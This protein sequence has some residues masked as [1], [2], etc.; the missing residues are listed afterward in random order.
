MARTQSWGIFNLDKQE[1]IKE[2]GTWHDLKS[3]LFT[4]SV[5]SSRLI[6]LLSLPEPK[7]LRK[8][9]GAK[10]IYIRTSLGQLNRIPLELLDMVFAAVDDIVDLA[11]LCLVNYHML[12]VGRKHFD[13]H[14]RKHRTWTGDRLICLGS[15]T[16]LKDLP[17]DLLTPEERVYYR[18]KDQ[19]NSMGGL[20]YDILEILYDHSR[21][22]RYRV[23]AD[24]LQGMQL[25]EKLI[26]WDLTD[27]IYPIDKSWVLC[28]LSKY[29]YVTARAISQYTSG[30]SVKGPYFCSKSIGFTQVLVSQICW[31]KS[32]DK[33]I[34][35]S[36]DTPL[37][38]GR[39]AG[40]RFEI[41]T[42]DRMKHLEGG[43]EWK[44]VSPMII[45][46]LEAIWRNHYGVLF[47][48][49]V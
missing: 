4:T 26:L 49:Y 22:P 23:P 3:I 41:T 45:Q 2:S 46:D 39:W 12:N 5:H 47:R 20:F 6:T 32:A 1:F 43:E 37:H 34:Q 35:G 13:M 21:N 16:K 36:K 24:R 14:L 30:K 9:D 19:E 8:L 27:P 38:K 15:S 31:A 25:N 11:C 7:E 28:N 42:M 10:E 40:D 48:Q 33:E 18:K 17:P 29:Q 44:D